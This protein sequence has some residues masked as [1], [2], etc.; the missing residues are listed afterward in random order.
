MQATAVQRAV[1]L[2]GTHAD[3]WV[4]TKTPHS[5]SHTPFLPEYTTSAGK[6]AYVDL[7]VQGKTAREAGQ[8]QAALSLFL[9]YLYLFVFIMYNL[10]FSHLLAPV[11]LVPILAWF[12]LRIDSL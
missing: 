1:S 3:D 10:V 5:A 6:L 7:I 11:N 2:T 9:R 8:T 4:S 12:L